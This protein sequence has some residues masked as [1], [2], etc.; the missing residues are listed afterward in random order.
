L[1]TFYVI[2]LH[3][4]TAWVRLA[5]IF[6]YILR[7][8]FTSRDRPGQGRTPYLFTCDVT[9]FTDVIDP[10]TMFVYITC[11]TSLPSPSVTLTSGTTLQNAAMFVLTLN[12]YFCVMQ[13][14][15]INSL[16]ML[17]HCKIIPSNFRESF[18]RHKMKYCGLIPR[19]DICLVL[20]T[21]MKQS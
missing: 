6:V 4:V 13:I 16:R 3:H 2:C 20:H 7:H 21:E 1:F 19:L 11:L 15:D 17:L 5:A 12:I 10:A 9:S 18:I 8:L 14:K